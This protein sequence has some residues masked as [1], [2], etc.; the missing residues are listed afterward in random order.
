MAVAFDACTNSSG[1]GTSLSWSHT[2]TG[3]DLVLYVY[4]GIDAA[5]DFNPSVTYNSVSMTPISEITTNRYVAVFRL[6]NPATGS[7]TVSVTGLP[8]GGDEAAFAV[9]FTGVNQSDPDDTPVT[10]NG[11]ATAEP[12][13]SNSIDVTS[14][15]GDMVL[16][17]MHLNATTFANISA[18]GSQTI[19][20]NG[21]VDDAS[22]EH[23]TSYAAG[24]STVT[25]TWNWNNNAVYAQ[26]ALNINAAAGGGGGDPEGS[27]I[28]GKLLRGG[29]LLGGVLTR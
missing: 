29:L 23:L 12:T 7:N 27:L 21:S 15:T 20:T 6:V 1:T 26:Y 28:Q 16:D 24:A 22:S 4:V 19:P 3:S 10:E 9:S 5:A 17:F 11:S 2:C 13:N 25:M 14:E 8:G 18:G